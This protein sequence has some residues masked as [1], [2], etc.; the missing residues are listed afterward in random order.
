MRLFNNGWLTSGKNCKNDET[1]LVLEVI[2]H[3][4]SEY[5][6][7]TTAQFIDGYFYE[8]ETGEKLSDIKAIMPIKYPKKLGNFNGQEKADEAPEDPA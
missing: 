2:I 1:Y 8:E 5:T 3:D 7:Y 6:R 4:E